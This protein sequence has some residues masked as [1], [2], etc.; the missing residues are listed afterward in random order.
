MHDDYKDH[1]DDA[2]W[3]DGQATREPMRSRVVDVRR[4]P[5]GDDMRVRRRM[6]RSGTLL[7]EGIVTTRNRD[8]LLR[9]I[10][11]ADSLGKQAQ[12]VRELDELEMSARR[13]AALEREVDF[14]SAVVGGTLTP[15]ESKTARS[16]GASDWLMDEEDPEGLDHTA[17]VAQAAVWFGRVSG[18][19]R[20]DAGEFAEQ[21]RGQARA[22]TSSASAVQTF[23]DYASFLRVQAGHKEAASGVD[24]IQQLTAPDGSSEKPTELPQDV[25]DNFAPPVAD[26]NAG[27]DEQTS[28]ERNPLMQEIMSNP[29]N[30]SPEQPGG[31]DTGDDLSWNP[32]GGGEGSAAP[33]QN[34]A[35]APT[36][37]APEQPGGHNGGQGQDQ[38]GGIDERARRAQAASSLPMIQQTTDVHD[39]PAATPL[40]TQVAFPWTM[41]PEDGL[42]G[43]AHYDTGGEVPSAHKSTAVRKRADQWTQPSPVIEPNIANSPASTPPRN[44]GEAGSG[45]A[46]AANP[47]AKPSFGDAHL[48]PAYTE[49]YTQ[50]K[51]APANQDVPVS[52]GGD[53]GQSLK[54]PAYASR[55]VASAQEMRHPDFQRGYK[56]ASKWQPTTPVVTPGSAELEAGIY[57]GLTDNPTHRS[58]WLSVH[59]ELAEREAGLGRRIQAHR[60]LTHKVAAAQGLPTDGTYLQSQAASGI[61]LDTTAPGTSPSPTGDTP[62]NGPGRPGPLAGGQDAAAPGGPSP[63]NGAPPFG[64]PV[65]PAS[66]P[67]TDGSSQTLPSS[68]MASPAGID[69]LHPTTAAFRRRVQAARL[70]ERQGN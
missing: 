20:A 15:V 2:D 43:E 60:A 61:D 3:R 34:S 8:D 23:L 68:G 58:A 36:S 47:N 57:A 41:G 51:Q 35:P 17:M 39:A 63:Y 31:H 70:N 46:D 9:E 11:A 49:G 25:F 54:H 16:T 12:L 33:T 29:G 13:T 1:L 69:S 52:L 26:I 21:A 38:D 40:P 50:N 53:N 66:S 18:E 42:E 14:A 48:A 32:E 22:L 65:V 45:A 19:V 55:K 64:Q 27:V 6:R 62:I 5:S 7:E 30:S 37:G 59:A 24:Q 56:Y 10:A 44:V 4:R 67:M 28:S